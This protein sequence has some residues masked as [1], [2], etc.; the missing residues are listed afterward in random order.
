MSQ[1]ELLRSDRFAPLFYTQFFGAFNDN[2]FRFALIIFVTFTVAERTGMDTRMLVVLTGG[3]FILPF[4]LFSALAGQIADRYEKSRLIRRIK[5]TEIFVMGLGAAGFWLEDLYFLLT[6]LFLMGAQSTFFGP[7]K[8]AILPQHLKETELT[9]GNG[10][11]QM[12]TYVA[13]L[14]GG[15]CGGMLASVDD[16][17][18]GLVIV[19]VMVLAVLGRLSAG[20]IPSA[21][22]SAAGMRIDLNPVRS[23]VRILR[24]AADEREVLTIILVISG[25]WFVGA[26][27]LSV[28]PTFGKE[29]LNADAQAVTLLNAAL[30]VGIGTGSLL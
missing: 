26:T 14:L 11:I 1:Y 25:F 5:T 3:I 22:P 4:F 20:Y 15:V 19:A 30:S 7:L 21:A 23:T 6:V 8:Y 2:V 12:G 29:L 17:G 16:L 28:M 18:P 13:I 9:G 10:L 24:D 27:Y